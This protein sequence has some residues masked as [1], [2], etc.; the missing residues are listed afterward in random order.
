[1]IAGVPTDHVMFTRAAA[2]AAETMPP[3]AL[4]SGMKD[5]V[6]RA[7]GNPVQYGAAAPDENIFVAGIAQCQHFLPAVAE[8]RITMRPAIARVENR[9]V[10]FTDGTTSQPDALLFGTGYR[11]SLP[12][13]A[14]ALAGM[15]RLDDSHIDLHEHTFHPELPGL[16]F[17]GLYDQV[18]PLL[19]VLELQARWI[20]YT[21]SGVRPAPTRT[22]M[23]EGLA[24]CRA[25]RG[26]PKNVLMHAMAL[27][28]ARRAG[29]EP[30]PA[31]WPELQRALLFGPLSPASFRLQG[32][33]S[34]ADAPERTAAN[35][36]AFGAISSPNLN[37]E[38]Q[39]LLRAIENSRTKAA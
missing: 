2:L 4:A 25:A 21:F 31:K 29:V 34:I 38:E 35:A 18:G 16:A 24:R 33:D 11:L 14:P 19:P 32:P 5:L 7:A 9:V 28:F 23:L 37:Q 22:E 10:H 6:L 13:L 39:H 3:E 15:L 17:L 30:D 8:G 26:G 20:S 1:M 12:W 36:A 27:L